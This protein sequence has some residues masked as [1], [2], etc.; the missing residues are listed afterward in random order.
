[1]DIIEVLRDHRD[2]LQQELGRVDEVL[3]ALTQSASVPEATKP[4]FKHHSSWDFAPQTGTMQELH[5]SERNGN[6]VATGYE[7]SVTVGYPPMKFLECN[8]EQIRQGSF[9]VID[10]RDMYTTWATPAGMRVRAYRITDRDM[11]A[12]CW[13]V[14]MHMVIY[15]RVNKD[16]GGTQLPET[17]GTRVEGG[18][19][20]L[21]VGQAQP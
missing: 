3:A 19:G 16:A 7:R 17:G 11:R 6:V 15:K 20:S 10:Q 14:P 4:R 12:G 9:T 8:A 5:I 1:M 13:Y 2:Q 21:T 18:R